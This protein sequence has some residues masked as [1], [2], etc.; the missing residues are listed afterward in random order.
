[1][2]PA[3]KLEI[4]DTQLQ[5]LILASQ[6][7]CMIST[8]NEADGLRMALWDGDV[9]YGPLEGDSNYGI[10]GLDL[11]G[12]DEFARRCN[13]FFVQRYNQ[14]GFLT[15]GYTTMGTG[16]H[17]WTLAQHYDLT[18]DRRW[19]AQIA[20]EV[21][22]VCH[23]I[24]RQ[25][26]KTKRLDPRGEK[27]PEYGLMPPGVE[28]DWNAMAY[29]FCLNGYFYAGL[30]GAGRVL[31]ENGH[32]DGPLFRQHAQEL[33]EEILRAF[34]RTQ[35]CS[36]VLP[37]RN[38]TW[39]PA[40]PSQVHCPGLTGGFFP[41][42]DG[43]RSWCYDVE[44]GAPHL[45]PQGILDAKSRDATWMLNHLED[46]QF[47]EEGWLYYPAEESQQ[48]PFNLG[49]FSKVQPYLTR[50]AQMY[51]LRDDVRPFLRAYFN[52]VASVVNLETLT[53]SE[54]FAGTGAST[55]SESMGHFLE[56]TRWM[57]LMES[58]DELWLAPFVT[59]NWLDDGMVVSI[60]DAPTRFGKVSYRICSSVA[61][62]FVTVVIEP[63]DRNPP[64]TLVVRVRHPDGKRMTRV[65]MNGTPHTQ[66]DAIAETVRVRPSAQPIT[67]VVR[68]QAL[69][70]P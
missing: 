59:N 29:Y 62:G 46:V 66:F 64:G 37:L 35:A 68:D 51:A 70:I 25:R 63:P 32:P 61:Q 39:V 6:V 52:A 48:D 41:G 10:L 31:G 20:P 42:E 3:M 4:P 15:M 49:G 47:L 44:E 8:R 69:P 19:F 18:N 60:R 17:L 67:V 23:W 50:A 9:V 43:N 24:V 11:L 30:D 57:L 45:V 38:G 55:N 27:M 36:P 56:Q 58:G 53:C 22:R 14:E 5:R 26:E 34:H 40:Y 1:M 13:D 33:K 7:H 16:W 28:A 2:D 12:H 21:A 54:H 65:T